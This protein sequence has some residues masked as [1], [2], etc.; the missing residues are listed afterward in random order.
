MKYNININVTKA[1]KRDILVHI[2]E[3]INE[4]VCDELDLPCDVPITDK[5]TLKLIKEAAGDAYDAVVKSAIK[6]I[7]SDIEVYDVVF[8]TAMEHNAV[9]RA[10][11]KIGRNK[12][13]C[14]TVSD[15]I[16]NIRLE[17]AQFAAKRAGMKLVK[18]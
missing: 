15:T 3:N 12:A 17:A 4:I 7:E 2:E 14:A 8:N 5:A 16:C 11:Q 13:V 18:A 10:A 9:L 1:D 6:E